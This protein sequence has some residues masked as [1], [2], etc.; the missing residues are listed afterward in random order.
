MC[1]SATR[2]PRF[3]YSNDTVLV[4]NNVIRAAANRVKAETNTRSKL[5]N[6]KSVRIHLQKIIA[7]EP[8]VSVDF[9][10]IGGLNPYSI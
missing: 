10:T 8:I 9:M 5:D 1:H 7:S 4:N 6:S 3:R 2:P